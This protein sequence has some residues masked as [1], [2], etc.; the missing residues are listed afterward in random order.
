MHPNVARVAHALKDA[1]ATGEPQELSDPAS[2]AA[3][4]ATQLGCPVGAIAN[5][6]VFAVDGEPLLV[7]TSGAHRVDTRLVATLVGAPSL[8]RADADFV[9]TH[10]GFPIGGVAPV[11]HPAPI[12]TLVD[13][14]LAKHET[15]WAGA[16]LPHWV[17]PTT[18]EELV[19]LSGGTV[20]D[21]APR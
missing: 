16:G 18:F 17:F 9:R 20:A 1:G 4:A 21:V 15:V 6:L 11:G 8:E 13:T 12:K 5:S 14:W 7:L 19:R 10:T 2:T 3:T